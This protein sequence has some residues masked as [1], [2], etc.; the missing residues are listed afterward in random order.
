[1]HNRSPNGPTP[2]P[3]PTRKVSPAHLSDRAGLA[4]GIAAL[5]G[6][7]TVSGCKVGPDY[8]RPESALNEA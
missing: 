6:V 1:M 8:Q 2:A 4:I 5:A 3:E 7:L